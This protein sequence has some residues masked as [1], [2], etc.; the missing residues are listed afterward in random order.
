MTQRK[1]SSMSVP[2]FVE[3]QI[4]AAQRQGVF[5]D[6]PGKGKPI[7]GIDRQQ[8]ELEWVA[9]YLKREDVEVVAV[10]PPQLALAKEVEDLRPAVAKLHSEARV[11]AHVEDLNARI[12]AAHRAPQVGPPFRVR[13]VDVE[14]VVEQ[15]RS[16][17]PAPAPRP[18]VAP[19]PPRRRWFRRP[20]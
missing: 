19:P 6:L 10:L 16:D 15:W 18:A 13:V 11:R 8:H 5:D 1:P 3:A 7:P 9:G 4:S 14:A 17:R 12:R 2:D 20:S